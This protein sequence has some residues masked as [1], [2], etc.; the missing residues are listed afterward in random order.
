MRNKFTEKQNLEKNGV[1]HVEQHI[2][3]G[4]VTG[5]EGDAQ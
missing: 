3:G 1:L 5:M 4:K 2:Y